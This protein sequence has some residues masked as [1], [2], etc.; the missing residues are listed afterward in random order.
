MEG[1][2]DWVEVKPNNKKVV[3]EKP[4]D[5]KNF[6]N[7]NMFEILEFEEPPVSEFPSSFEEQKTKMNFRDM[8][9]TK[10]PNK[11]TKNKEKNQ[12]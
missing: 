6:Q 12:I 10:E 1:L 9:R 11:N 8:M 7:K 3:F 5:L 2:N 4:M